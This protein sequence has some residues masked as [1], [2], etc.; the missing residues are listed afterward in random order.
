M[1]SVSDTIDGNP[2]FQKQ[3]NC[4]RITRIPGSVESILVAEV[5]DT[6]QAVCFNG[7]HRFRSVHRDEANILLLR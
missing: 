6:V 3:Q 1:K 2:E 7:K 4:C 5:G